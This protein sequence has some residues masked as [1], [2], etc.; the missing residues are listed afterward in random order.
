MVRRNLRRLKPTFIDVFVKILPGRHRLADML[1]LLVENS[2]DALLTF[3]KN[4]QFQQN[5]S[6]YNIAVFVLTATINAY[7]EL[8]KLSAKVRE[9]L[10]AVPLKVGSVIIS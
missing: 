1:K 2:F 9:H 7:T 8:T 4:L 3:D 10:I 6:K 5:L